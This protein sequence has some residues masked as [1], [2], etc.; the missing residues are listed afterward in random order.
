MFTKC[1]HKKKEQYQC[2]NCKGE[3]YYS[4]STTEHSF[5]GSVTDTVRRKCLACK[6]TGKI[7][8]EQ[9]VKIS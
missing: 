4:V 1:Q 8:E 9:L 7:S 2:P 5:F 6:G 3:G